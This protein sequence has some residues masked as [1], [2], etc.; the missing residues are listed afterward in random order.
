VI[1]TRHRHL[2]D[3]T[4]YIREAFEKG[5]FAELSFEDSPPFGISVNRLLTSPQP[6]Q[7][8][9]RLFEFVGYDVL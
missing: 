7:A 3:L 8:G 5:G 6:L 9:I 2:P 1:W 4:S